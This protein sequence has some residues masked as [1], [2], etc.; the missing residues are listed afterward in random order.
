MADGG[1]AKIAEDL[2]FVAEREG[3]AI[4]IGLDFLRDPFVALFEAIVDYRAESFFG[5]GVQGFAGFGIA[6]DYNAAAARDQINEA[7]ESELVGVEIGVD[8]GMI[9]F[10]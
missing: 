7:T 4:T 5:D 10:E 6:P 8:V 1:Q 9:E 2:A 3:H